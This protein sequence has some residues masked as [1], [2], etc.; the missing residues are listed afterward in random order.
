[1]RVLVVDD[2]L[3]VDTNIFFFQYYDR[4]TIQTGRHGTK[5]KSNYLLI[6]LFYKEDGMV[7]YSELLNC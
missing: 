7:G 5:D 1:M 4:H 2:I 3:D 6:S